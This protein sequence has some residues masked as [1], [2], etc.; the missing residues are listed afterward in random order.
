M[1]IAFLG[2]IALIGKYDISLHDKQEVYR[3]FDVMRPILQACD[4]VIANLESPL[5]HLTTTREAK[6]MPLRS[7]PINVDVLKYLNI[8]A[9][10]LANN[11]IYDYGKTGAQDTMRILDQHHINYVG[12]ANNALSLARDS[13]LLQGFCCFSTNGWHYDCGLGK[14]QL[15]ALTYRN[16][17]HFLQEAKRQNA[18]PVAV[19]HWGDEN[20]HYPKPQHITM[21]RYMLSKGIPC[22]VGH[23]PHVPQGVLQY[24]AGMC[25]FSLGNFI[26]DDCLCEKNGVSVKQTEDNKKGFVLILEFEQKKLVGWETVSYLDTTH[27]IEVDVAAKNLLDEYSQKIPQQEPD[28]SY[29]ALRQQEQQQAHVSRLGKRDWV[30]LKNHCN[31]S[32]V[33]SVLQRKINQWRFY[34]EVKKFR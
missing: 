20:T 7:N 14:G 11:H 24:S 13:I 31:Y 30:W 25:A 10:S 2:D 33:W 21:A 26:F 19:I 6:S 16:V 29:R 32:A 28:A 5:T 1:K 27:G 8:R 3:R 15:H 18:C 17:H 22:I 9:V 34:R 12:L 23:H 4:F